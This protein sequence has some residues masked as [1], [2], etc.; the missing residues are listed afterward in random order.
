MLNALYPS[1]EPY[2]IRRIRVDD[3][4][5]IHVEECG[6]P[7]GVPVIFLHGGPGSGCGDDHR[8]FFDPAFYRIVLFDQRGAGRSSPA[9]ETRNNTSADLISDME[10]IRRD[11]GI[12][13]WMLFGGSW[14][15]TLAL[16]YAQ[17]HPG[18]V[19][20]MV[21]RGA[22]LARETDLVW[23]F[24][25]LRRLL[26]EAWTRFSH[27]VG[28]ADDLIAGYYQALRGDD[29]TR[30]L[31]AARAWDAWGSEVVN[32]QRAR[33][34]STAD[35]QAPGE[36]V[37]A[38]IRL[39]THYAQHRYFIEDNRLLD[40]ADSLPEVPVSIV[41]GRLDLACNLLAAWQLQR[42]I[43]GSR[44][45]VLERAGHLMSEPDMAQALVAETD[46]LRELL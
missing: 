3:I 34:P 24:R 20:A 1:I 18:R 17:A 37:L 6:R 30:A 28:D 15:A 19:S 42:A 10:R 46:R 4:H 43:P 23:F 22:F 21:L 27:A 32:W 13:R 25:D 39:E 35:T 38:K 9:G 11:L 7:D 2:A 16:L 14:G 29:R 36:H 40:R 12:E 45:V 44:L 5:E 33:T 8:R 41:H 31:R 26:P